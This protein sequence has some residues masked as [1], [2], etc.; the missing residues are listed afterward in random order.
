M[1]YLTRSELRTHLYD[2][3]FTISESYSRK[4]AT[5]GWKVK[6]FLSHC[7]ADAELIEAAELILKNEGVEIYK[8]IDDANMP[9]ITSPQTAQLIKEKIEECDRFIMIAGESAIQESRWVPWELGFAD[10]KKPKRV[11]IIPVQDF[12]G[13]WRG[14]EYVG[15]YPTIEGSTLNSYIVSTPDKLKSAYLTH[16]LKMDTW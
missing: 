8:D 5:A 13:Q 2:Q 10:G 16:W 4:L 9:K 12:A 15:L 6:V 7:R 3:K 11:A 1:A 14:A